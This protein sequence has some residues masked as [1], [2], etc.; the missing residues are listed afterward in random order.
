MLCETCEKRE[1]CSELCPEAELFV[2]QDS[3]HRLEEPIGLLPVKKFIKPSLK[4]HTHLTSKEKEILMLLGKG[5]SR[6]D[7]CQLL[8]ITPNSLQVHL[9]NAKKKYLK[10]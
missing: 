3:V 4:K 5:L 2:K 8:N 10:S 7:V 9:S 6:V 1:Y